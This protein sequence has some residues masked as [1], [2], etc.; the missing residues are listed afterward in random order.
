MVEKRKLEG[1]VITFPDGRRGEILALNVEGFCREADFVIE[2]FGGDYGGKELMPGLVQGGTHVNTYLLGKYLEEIKEN[3]ETL[4][5]IGE[6]LSEVYEVVKKDDDVNNYREL[7]RD[8]KYKEA[9]DVLHE[10]P[11][12][13]SVLRVEELAK[14][15]NAITKTPRCINQDDIRNFE[16]RIETIIFGGEFL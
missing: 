2:G 11:E 16:K 4:E 8:K 7:V 1:A 13:I 12:V 9:Y 5:E 6:N 10:N 14:Y 3:M 15:Y